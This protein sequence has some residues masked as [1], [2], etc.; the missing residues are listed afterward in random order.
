M[1]K[2]KKSPNPKHTG[3]TG[4]NEKTKPKNNL[5]RRE[6]KFPNYRAS[7]F[8]QNCR[9]KKKHLNQRKRYLWIYKK[10]TELQID[11]TRK[12]IPPIT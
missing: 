10:P 6:R 4:Y 9:G 11:L 5:Y 3:N 7:E 12:E 8:Q 1:Q 2:A